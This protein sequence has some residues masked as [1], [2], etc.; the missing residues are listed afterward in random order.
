MFINIKL[1]TDNEYVGIGYVTSGAFA[2]N[3]WN[4]SEKCICNCSNYECLETKKNTIL[5]CILR[6]YFRQT[7]WIHS[8]LRKTSVP[9]W[10][11]GPFHSA[12]FYGSENVHRGLLLDE[13]TLPNW[14]NC[15]VACPMGPVWDSG[16]QRAESRRVHY[17]S[18]LIAHTCACPVDSAGDSGER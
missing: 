6:V 12:V 4:V 3:R 18:R 14:T 1:V 11:L 15:T 9:K 5:G 8:V 13:S 7:L 17:W 10:G 16:E 2:L